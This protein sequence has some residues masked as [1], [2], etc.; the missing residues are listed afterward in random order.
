MKQVVSAWL[1]AA[2]LCLGTLPAQAAWMGLVDG[3]YLVDL[4]CTVSSQITCP[5]TTTGTIT[6]SGSEVV[7][8]D[9]TIDGV[10]FVGDPFDGLFDGTLVDFEG[11]TL[12]TSGPFQ[13]LSLRL[14]TDGQIGSFDT[15]DRWWVYC[16]TAGDPLSCTP[17]T[18]GLWT[19]TRLPSDVP[20]PAMPA[21]LAA[22]LAALGWQARRRR[23]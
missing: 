18:T 17:N 1:S 6:V 9:F 13:F 19:A 15:G 3:D 12:S 23:R 7:A 16:N 22:A 4:N 10:S 8:M 21:L 5:S 20:E 11:S 14:I 2:L